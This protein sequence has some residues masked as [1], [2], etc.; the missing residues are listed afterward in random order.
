MYVYYTQA[1]RLFIKDEHILD[2]INYT[3]AAD[4]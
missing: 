3:H 2:L 4:T 1:Y